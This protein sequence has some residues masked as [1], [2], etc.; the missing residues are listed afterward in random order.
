MP[1]TARRDAAADLFI[2]GDYV[3][4]FRPEDRL[5][6]FRAI[7]AR[8]LS[9][10]LFLLDRAL[11][12]LAGKRILD[13]GGGMGRLSIPL[14]GAGARAT[15]LD[16]S[17]A[18]I[19]EAR[20]RGEGGRQPEAL[21]ADATRLPF[22]DGAFDA[23]VGLDL[24]CHLQDPQAGL[25]ELKRVVRPGGKLLLDSTNSNPLWVIFYPRYAG[26]SPRKWASALLHDGL[27]PGWVGR[28]HHY[29]Q[30]G[31]HDELRRAGLEIEETR[32]YGPSVCPKWHLALTTVREGKGA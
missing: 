13:A 25:A 18:M 22:R 17:A 19:Q 15:L 4:H 31:F 28:V 14:A 9:D 1:E 23:V 29:R 30:A 20:R 2:S 12:G 8:K 7:Y 26:L 5:N 16:L 24:F 21:V 6:P 32:S 27:L 3:R 10:T 11:R